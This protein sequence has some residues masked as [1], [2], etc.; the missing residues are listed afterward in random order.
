MRQILLVLMIGLLPRLADAEEIALDAALEALEASNEDWQILSE[1]I[2]QARARRR[3]A[4]AQLLPQLSAGASLSY[5][6]SEVVAGDRVVRREFDRSVSGSASVTLFDGAAYPE[7]SQASRSLEATQLDVR[8]QQRTLRFEVERTFFELAAAQRDLAIAAQT[9]EL[10]QAY[11]DRATALEAS[12]IALPLDVARAT[13]QRLEAQQALLEADTRTGVAANSLALLLGREPDAELRAAPTAATPA[14]PAAVSPPGQR[15][16]LAAGLK[17]IDAARALESARW[18]ALAPRLDL[19]SDARYG[20]PSFSAPDGIT[21]S[22]TLGA[23]WLLYDGGARYAR[24]HAA[25]SQL[26]EVGLRQTQQERVARADLANALRRWRTAH[27]AIAVAEQQVKVAREAYDMTV[28]RAESGLATSIEVTE[29]SDQLF[30]AESTLSSAQL[31]AD[32]AAAT[33]RYL[34]EAS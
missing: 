32:V 31:A 23:T 9:V 21:W 11:V 6:G 1:R 10:R 12:G 4:V 34:N 22:I 19:R 13:V 20:L 2:A 28:A 30:R 24:L 33:F 29:S 3:E 7:I 17:L 5:N 25:Q 16:D 15:S 14:P 18:W 26:R 8:W 27:Q